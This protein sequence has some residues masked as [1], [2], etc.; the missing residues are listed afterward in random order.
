M[1]LLGPVGYDFDFFFL[2]K[3]LRGDP[4]GKVA[5]VKIDNQSLDSLEKT[6]LRVLSL[7]KTVFAKM[8]DALYADGAKA[9][10]IDVI[11][12]NRSADE[13]ALAEAFL[14][15]PQTVIGAKIGAR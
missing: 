13:N 1:A 7:S 4:T 15:Y 8:L 5:I 11:F 10:G 14:K 9:V 3:V 6:D 2:Y 12:A